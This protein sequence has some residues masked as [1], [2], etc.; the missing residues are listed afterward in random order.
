M[1]EL[2]GVNNKMEK[3]NQMLFKRDHQQYFLSKQKKGQRPRGIRLRG[4]K[5]KKKVKTVAE[6]IKQQG[7][8]TIKHFLKKGEIRNSRGERKADGM[9]FR[10]YRILESVKL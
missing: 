5:K 6:M 4:V 7:E 10:N 9:I 8:P 2:L 1:T 3:V